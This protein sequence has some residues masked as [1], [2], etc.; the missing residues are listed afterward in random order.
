M[1]RSVRFMTTDTLG[2]TH[3]RVAWYL[4]HWARRVTFQA[5]IL[6]FA[7]QKKPLRGFVS[8]VAEV[9]SDTYRSMNVLRIADELVV[10]PQAKVI[11]LCAE[12]LGLFVGV[13]GRAFAF[14]EWLMRMHLRGDRGR[15]RREQIRGTSDRNCGRGGRTVGGVYAGE[16][17]TQEA[18]FGLRTTARKQQGAG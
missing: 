1:I 6:R 15:H 3:R 5:E 14:Q 18:I 2:G 9:A 17:D 7:C 10:A 11:P 12:L 8:L 16:E 4:L 13:A